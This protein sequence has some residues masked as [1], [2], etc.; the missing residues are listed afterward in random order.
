MNNIPEELECLLGNDITDV[1]NAN[2]QD[3]FGW[4]D[5]GERHK[6]ALLSLNKLH[7]VLREVGTTVGFPGNSES[8]NEV[9]PQTLDQGLAE[10][11][12]TTVHEIDVWKIRSWNP[13]NYFPE[14]V[15]RNKSKTNTMIV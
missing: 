14:C 12:V 7:L 1:D 5:A 13:S 2:A 8:S 10:S 3:W 9:R 15:I 6:F 4:L 11:P